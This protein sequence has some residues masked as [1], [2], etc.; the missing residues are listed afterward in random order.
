MQL[1]AW[2]IITGALWEF[3]SS[4]LL[5][6]GALRAAER[7]LRDGARAALPARAAVDQRLRRTRRLRRASRTS[8]LPGRRLVLPARRL[9]LATVFVLLDVAAFVVQGV[10]GVMAGPGADPAVARAGLRVYTGGVAGQLGCICV[11]GGLLALLRARL[12]RAGARGRGHQRRAGA[13]RG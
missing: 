4:V 10:G 8:W 2:T 7:R 5:A 11:F 1:Y 6:L 3:L 12:A 9:R 13:G